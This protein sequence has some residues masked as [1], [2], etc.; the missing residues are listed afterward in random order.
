MNKNENGAKLD[1]DSFR[2]TYIE[3]QKLS[4]AEWTFVFV[5]FAIIIGINLIKLFGGA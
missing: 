2:E 1:L 5:I 4:R 3:P